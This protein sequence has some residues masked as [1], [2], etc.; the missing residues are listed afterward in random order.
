MLLHPPPQRHEWNALQS[1]VGRPRYNQNETAQP[2]RDRGHKPKEAFES[3]KKAI[4]QHRQHEQAENRKPGCGETH[5]GRLEVEFL[6]VTFPEAGTGVRQQET[7]VRHWENGQ[8]G[9]WAATGEGNQQETREKTNKEHYST[10]SPR[11]APRSTTEKAGGEAKEEID[12]SRKPQNQG[13]KVRITS[14]VRS[15]QMQTFTCLDA[16][17]MLPLGQKSI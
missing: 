8:K 11:P 1:E 17:D 4:P 10:T 16:V 6:P 13:Q 9:H 14:E 15:K 2:E 7:V 12:Q 5:Q 3:R